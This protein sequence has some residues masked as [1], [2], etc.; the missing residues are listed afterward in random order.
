[1]VW[2]ALC[3]PATRTIR[4]CSLDGRS[5]GPTTPCPGRGRSEK[6]GWEGFA[7]ERGSA[8]TQLADAHNK[9]AK[10]ASLKQ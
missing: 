6:K 7:A 2:P 9:A 8:V 10:L 5:G 1:V 3:A 4:M